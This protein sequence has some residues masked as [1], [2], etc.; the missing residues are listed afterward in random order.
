MRIYI[1]ED[2][3]SVIGILEDIVEGNELG[4]VCGDSGGEPANLGQILALDPD[5]VLVDL[6]MP[7]KDGIQVVRELKEQ[8]CRAKFIMIS[9]V[10]NKEMVAKA[11]LAGVDFFINKPIN[12][13]EVR[14]VILNVRRQLENERDLHT[15][16]SV[17]AEKAAPVGRRSRLEAQRKRI[18]TTLSQLGMAGEK[19][20]RDI[21]ELC[22][23]LLEQ[24]QQVSQVG[25]GALCAQLSDS[26]KSMEQRARRAVERGLHHLASL[27]LEDYGNEIFTLYAS[28]LFPFQEVR[29]EMACIQG[30]RERPISSVFWTGC[31]C[32]WRRTEPRS[33][34]QLRPEARPP[35]GIN[36]RSCRRILHSAAAFS[37][38]HDVRGST[39]EWGSRSE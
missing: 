14:Q 4:V 12:L 33:S 28:R 13:I 35:R 18:Q 16:Q 39:P 26:P 3:T 29:A 36:N 24:G 23:L 25:V 19:G 20:A 7:Q 17:F 6:L 8:G 32:W 10:S 9:Q 1:V 38:P 21:V 27:G 11:Y 31:W 34:L 2:D 5:L 37:F 15:I 22:M 30:P